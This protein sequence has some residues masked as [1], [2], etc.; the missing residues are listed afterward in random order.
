[1]NFNSFSP[2]DVFSSSS[3]SN[4]SGSDNSFQSFGS[5][6]TPQSST[7]FGSWVSENHTP[8]ISKKRSSME[9][10]TETKDDVTDTNDLF[11]MMAELTKGLSQISIVQNESEMQRYLYIACKITDKLQ[12]QNEDFRNE[13]AEQKQLNA[14]RERLLSI[15]KDDSALCQFV[16]EELRGKFSFKVSRSDPVEFKINSDNEPVDFRI[17]PDSEML[18]RFGEELLPTIQARKAEI[19][20]MNREQVFELCPPIRNRRFN[21][22][23]ALVLSMTNYPVNYT[24]DKKGRVN[25]AQLMDENVYQCVMDSEM[26]K[27]FAQ[28]DA[29]CIPEIIREQIDNLSMYLNRNKHSQKKAKTG[30]TAN[31]EIDTDSVD[32]LFNPDDEE[33]DDD[34]DDDN[35]D[36]AVGV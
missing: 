28:E 36:A 17:M 12:Q 3:S 13:L 15:S 16:T 4:S 35:D 30:Q 21:I 7:P 32:A 31:E 11:A 6:K 25:W 29:S 10:E 14:N 2:P 34:D 20:A 22:S 26:M 9:M 27:R 5:S 19:S 23:S 33:D 1:M 8:S 24:L 18:V